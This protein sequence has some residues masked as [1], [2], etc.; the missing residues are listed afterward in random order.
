MPRIVRVI[1]AQVTVRSTAIAASRVST[2][3][4]RLPAGGPEIGLIQ[5]PARYHAG[6]FSA[7]SRAAAVTIAGSCGCRW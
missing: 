5:L 2:Q 7:A 6:A 4:G 1:R 3:T